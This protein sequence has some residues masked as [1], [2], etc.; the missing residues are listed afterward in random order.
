MKKSIKWI[1][2]IFLIAIASFYGSKVA[3]GQKYT[4]RIIEGGYIS[5]FEAVVIDSYEDYEEFISDDTGAS[6]TEYIESIKRDKYDKNYFKNK[7]LALVF[8]SC[9]PSDSV[10]DV[11]FLRLG[12]TLNIMAAIKTNQNEAYTDVISG[13]IVLVEVEKDVKDVSIY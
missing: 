1:G 3:D 12:K 7:S 11:N 5:D 6:L 8:K 10:L 9:H 4:Y 2:I 13:F